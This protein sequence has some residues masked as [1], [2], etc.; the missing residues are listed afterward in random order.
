MLGV[1]GLLSLSG[2]AYA[3][4]FTSKLSEREAFRLATT[5]YYGKAY[6]FNNGHWEYEGDDSKISPGF[7]AYQI[8]GPFGGSSDFVAVNPRTG[9]VW[10]T[11]ECKKKS[12]PQSRRLQAR[13]KKGLARRS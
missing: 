4:D 3:F 13:I 8:L 2:S 5:A 9:D 7:Y 1:L 6:H 12:T 10:S 11:W